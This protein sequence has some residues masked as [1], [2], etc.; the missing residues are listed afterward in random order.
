MFHVKHQALIDAFPAASAN[1][2]SYA[3]WLATDGVIRGLIGPREVERIWDRHLANCAALAELIPSGASVIDIGSGA[4][5]PGLVLAIVRPDCQVT[6]VEPLLRRSEFLQEVAT[7]L[8]LTNVEVI[9]ARAE[10]VKNRKAR[11]VTAR[12]V[13]PLERLLGWAMPLVAPGGELLAM[14]GSNAAQEIADAHGKL[15]KYQVEIHQ[16][17]QAIVDPPTTIVRV[18]R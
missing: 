8:N 7:D 15:V 16:V 5:L 4:G 14:K 3:N 1:L 11:I 9:R 10:Q 2:E 6:L 17:G 12:A 13:A 18:T